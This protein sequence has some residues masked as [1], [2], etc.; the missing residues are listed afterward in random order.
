MAQKGVKNTYQLIYMI[1]DQLMCYLTSRHTVEGFVTYT[2]C[3]ETI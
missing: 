3:N 2:K 1:S